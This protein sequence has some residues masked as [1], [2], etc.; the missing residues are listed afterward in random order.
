[1]R[2]GVG[3]DGSS[4][5]LHSRQVGRHGAAPRS[6][7]GLPRSLLG[8]AHPQLHLLHLRGRHQARSSPR[9]AQ[10]RPPRRG[11]PAGDR[12]SP[13]R[14]AGARSTS[15]T[16]S[17][18]CVTR[19]A[20]T[21]P[22]TASTS[23]EADWHSGEGGHGHFIPLHGGYHAIPP[24]DQL[25]NLRTEMCIDA[26]GDGRAG[27][28]PPPRGGRPG[29]VRDRDAAAGLCC[30]PATPPRSIKYVAKMVAHR[31]GQTA[32]FMPKP[33]YG[34]AGSGMHFHQKLLKGGKNRLLRRRGL[35]PARA[36]WRCH[37]IGGML[38]PRPALLALTNPSTNSYRR[39]VPGFEAPVNAFFSP[40]QPQ[41]RDPRP[42]VRRPAGDGAH[43]VPPA[44]R[45]LQRLPRAGGAS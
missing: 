14:A 9:S 44:G 37:Y 17:T 12:A 40:R 21:P 41:R 2:D 6:G 18:T 1:M 31:R 5:G 27:E 28:V 24:K 34:E 36:S 7:H 23:A 43:R 16:S 20:S 33:L 19:T 4:V 42:E 8:G 25:Y 22:P 38:T 39:L 3:F 32:T 11:V 10:H 29:P 30:R 26:G 35:R 15:S 45:H 13:T